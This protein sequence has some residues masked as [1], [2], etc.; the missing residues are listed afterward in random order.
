MNNY[1]FENENE[2]EDFTLDLNFLNLENT[3]EFE[4]EKELF[5]EEQNKEVNN[6]TSSFRERNYY[7]C[8]IMENFN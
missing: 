1:N 8:D 4:I 6:F 3:E 2:D 5:L 7:G